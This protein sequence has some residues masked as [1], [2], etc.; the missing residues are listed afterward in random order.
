M[1]KI[2]DTTE[3]SQEKEQIPVVSLSP[4]SAS[5]S[6]DGEVVDAAGAIAGG[7]GD[8]AVLFNDHLI[9]YTRSIEMPPVKIAT[10]DCL[11][12]KR[13]GLANLRIT[14]RG[15]FSYS[16]AIGRAPEWL[17]IE[18]RERRLAP[19]ENASFSLGLD[20]GRLPPGRVTG[21]GEIVISRPFIK[22]PYSFEVKLAVEYVAP[23]PRVEIEAVAGEKTRTL[24]IVVGNAGGGLL[25]GY[26]Y[27]RARNERHTFL[28]AGDASAQGAAGSPGGN[29]LFRMERVFRDFDEVRGGILVLCDCINE[30]FRR[31]EIHPSAY[32]DKEPFADASV[33]DFMR[34]ASGQRHER[35]IT[36]RHPDFLS[37][38]SVVI[39]PRLREHLSSRPGPAGKV[40]F[41][42]AE[43]ASVIGYVADYVEFDGAGGRTRR[44][45]VIVSFS[46][47]EQHSRN[48]P[49]DAS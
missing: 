28:L 25:E 1:N 39:P 2:D 37:R 38:C 47:G 11:Q 24:R 14:N 31:F 16:V 30:R 7:A 46:G 17:L 9:V 36:V 15:N 8:R 27:D 19:G 21:V 48:N 32:F 4:V 22:L 26:Y 42:L 18:E 34:V 20:Q 40:H 10:P 44:L 13:Y 35:E 41:L 6:S 12:R 33:I 3:N 43:G 5:D 49:Y 29:R 45:P 23:A